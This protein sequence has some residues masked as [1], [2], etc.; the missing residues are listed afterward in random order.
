[1]LGE[2][3][4]ASQ[5]TPTPR[6]VRRSRSLGG[7]DA[8]QEHSQDGSSSPRRVLSLDTH[9]PT[10]DSATT[11]SGAGMA[12]A[13]QT[14]PASLRRRHKRGHGRG[15]G[16]SASTGDAT[17]SQA[18]RARGGSSA[19]IK[20]SASRTPSLRQRATEKA[21]K[22]KESL[23]DRAVSGKRMLGLSFV[24]GVLSS[25]DA[26]CQYFGHPD[27]CVV[28]VVCG[29]RN[30]CCTY[31]SPLL[32]RVGTLSFAGP[33]AWLTG[34]LC[35][36]PF[37]HSYSTWQV[38]QLVIGRWRDAVLALYLA[39]LHLAAGI[40]LVCS[41]M[42]LAGSDLR[43]T[44]E[45]LA[46][47]WLSYFSFLAMH[48]CAPSIGIVWCVVSLCSEVHC[49]ELPCVAG[50]ATLSSQW[51][52][53]LS[54]GLFWLSF[55]LGLALLVSGHSLNVACAWVAQESHGGSQPACEQD[56][57]PAHESQ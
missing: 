19:E 47:G 49:A 52:W 12:R 27:M 18:S 5:A 32:S 57:R 54:I 37:R 22:P 15:R 16:G 30:A 23:L 8:E 6:H 44:L 7:S 14:P 2:E 9:T 42:W 56:W 39:P 51:S 29:L 24:A 35:F 25:A 40:G 20:R 33:S 36:Q 11:S 50:G 48:R 53:G 46:L 3:F 26:F 34:M 4:T 13:T 1:M 28:V 45:R 43:E 31:R 55:M 21:T 38:R 10:R 17:G 41:A